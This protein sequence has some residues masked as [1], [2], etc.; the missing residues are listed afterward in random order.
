MRGS[1]RLNTVVFGGCAHKFKF[2]YFNKLPTNCRDLEK[3]RFNSRAKLGKW[4]F[5]CQRGVGEDRLAVSV[6]DSE[7]FMHL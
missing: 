3:K 4:P 6:Y 5:K 7:R 2:N 1:W